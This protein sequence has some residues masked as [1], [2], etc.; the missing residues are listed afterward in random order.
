[1][2]NPQFTQVTLSKSE[3]ENLVSSRIPLGYRFQSVYA[4]DGGTFTVLCVRKS[5]IKL[6]SW[7]KA[8]IMGLILNGSWIEAVKQVKV[9]TGAGL[10]DAKNYVDEIRERMRKV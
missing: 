6:E 5:E 10:A 2:E 1:M 9:W 7:E 4:S 8:E 3:I